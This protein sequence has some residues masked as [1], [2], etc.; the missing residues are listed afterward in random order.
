LLD[1]SDGLDTAARDAQ[2]AS[3]SLILRTHY[4]RE[5]TY[6]PNVRPWAFG[7]SNRLI[8]YNQKYYSQQTVPHIFSNLR[9]QQNVRVLAVEKLLP[10]LSKKY[11][12]H[13]AVTDAL[14]TKENAA[15]D[16]L[17]YWNQTGRRHNEEYFRTMNQALITLAFG[18]ISEYKPMGNGRAWLKKASRLGATLNKVSSRPVKPYYYV[19][20]FDNWRF[21]EALVS[22]T[23]PVALDFRYWQ[24]VYPEMPEPGVHYVGVRDFDFAGTARQLMQMTQ[25]EI[26]Q[27]AE[28]GKSWAL[29][30]YSPVAVANRLLQMIKSEFPVHA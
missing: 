7:L 17:D 13:T 23:C 11:P 21:W 19:H 30:H 2:N 14:S 9:V 22:N 26:R 18:G 24:C 28:S 5:V 10:L 8:T 1:D 6:L 16:E 3:F 29:Q 27:V 12:V 25:P 20:N 15:L 4:N